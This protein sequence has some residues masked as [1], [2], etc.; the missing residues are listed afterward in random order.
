MPAPSRSAESHLALRQECWR[1]LWAVL[2][3]PLDD[4]DAA[5]GDNAQAEP[6]RERES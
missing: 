4:E 2:L 5:D 6:A 1:Q 3:R